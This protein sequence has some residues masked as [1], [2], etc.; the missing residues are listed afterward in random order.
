MEPHLRGCTVNP[1]LLCLEGGGGGSE[2]DPHVISFSSV[3]P[4]I[5]LIL[6]FSLSEVYGLADFFSSGWAT[7]KTGRPSRRLH[8][9]EKS[10]RSKQ[11][12]SSVKGSRVSLWWLL[13]KLNCPLIKTKIKKKTPSATLYE[14]EPR[15]DAL[16]FEIMIWSWF[17]TLFIFLSFKFFSFCLL[18]CVRRGCSVK[19]LPWAV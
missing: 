19:C 11:S 12:R 4:L 13:L 3:P 15:I 2:L 18:L 7:S 6:F 9:K 5:T 8:N 1:G 16:K 14:P 10:Q 17:I